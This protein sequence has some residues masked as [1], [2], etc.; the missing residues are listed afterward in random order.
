[1]RP[2]AGENIVLPANEFA[3]QFDAVF[4][5]PAQQLDLVAFFDGPSRTGSAV[6]RDIEAFRQSWRRPKWHFLTADPS[7]AE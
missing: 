3:R 4:G 5:M 2:A 6:E 1:M 7:G